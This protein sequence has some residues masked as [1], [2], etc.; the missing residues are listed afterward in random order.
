M[1]WGWGH[2]PSAVRTALPCMDPSLVSFAWTEFLSLMLLFSLSVVSDSLRPHGLQHTRL[3]CPSP[4]PRA[5]LNSRPLSWWYHPI[6]SSSV[7]LLSLINVHKI[8][9]PYTHVPSSPTLT[10]SHMC[11]CLVCFPLLEFKFTEVRT[12]SIFIHCSVPRT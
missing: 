7:V 1:P 8:A 2:L 10:T 4:P 6:I 9:M 12:L 5:C 11:F 3:C